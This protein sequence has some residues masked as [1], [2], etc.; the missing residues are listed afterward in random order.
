MTNAR[1]YELSM[2]AMTAERVQTSPNHPKHY[3]ARVSVGVPAKTIKLHCHFK[4]ATLA[5]IWAERF[6]ER[7]REAK[8]C[9]D[10]KNP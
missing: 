10:E 5:V 9:R 7:F 2:I 4:T 1:N 6:V 3:I 8:K